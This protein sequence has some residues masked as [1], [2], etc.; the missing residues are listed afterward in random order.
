[1]TN[2]LRALFARWPS[3][4]SR[5]EQ[6]ITSLLTFVAIL[7]VG[8]VGQ[9]FVHPYQHLVL[10][11]SMGASALLLLVIPNSPLAQPYPFVAGHLVPA[12]IGVACAQAVDDFYLAAALTVSLS[13]GAMYLLNCLHPPGGAAALVPIIARDQQVLDYSYVVFPVL[14][15]V[16]TLLTLVLVAHKW[17]LKKEYPVKPMARSDVRHHHD[18]PSPLARL[19][20]SGHDL[21]E[22][23]K[24]YGAYLNVTENDLTRVYLQ[25]QQKAHVR[26]FGEIRVRD[27]MSKDVITVEYG[28]DLEEAWALLRLH[29]VKI[30]PVIDKAR[31]VIGVLSLVDFLK[32]ADLKTY[33]GF[34]DKLIEFVRRST[35]VHT[36]KPEA[37]G[38]IMAQPAFTVNENDLIAL[39]VPLLSDKGLHHVPVVNDERRLV[40][41]VTQS[42]LIA[43]LFVGAV[44]MQ[45]A[46]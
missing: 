39:L 24:E 37:V 10:V 22:A 23:L 9:Q 45:E 6:F 29:K 31:R 20:I 11:A 28:T 26:K 4:L 42:D 3:T 32:R 8:R 46:A 19:G 7:I 16:I 38:Q 27:I 43:A 36:H 5:R 25:A 41:I 14:I 18:D 34:A 2:Y 1:M 40:G 21:Q 17:I 44:E 15:N 13:L 35:T 33:R 30:L 12:V